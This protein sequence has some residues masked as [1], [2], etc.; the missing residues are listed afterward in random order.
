MKE[1]TTIK[2]PIIF[3]NFK[4]YY[5]ATGERA[6]RL[7]QLCEE[8]AKR[9]GFDIRL[10]VQAADIYH[11]SE[12][13]SLPIYAEHID[14][15]TPGRSTGFILPED[16]HEEGAVGTILNHSEHRLK[17]TVLEQSVNRAREVGLKMVIC[18]ATPEE[19]ESFTTLKP[20]FIAVEPPELI[21]GLVSVSS[22]KPEIISDAVKRIP[23]P[24]L[25][26]AGIHTGADINTALKLG[27]VG[28]LIASSV[29]KSIDPEKA[30]K[31]LLEEVTQP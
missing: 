20:D 8:F 25:V 22:A 7:A 1:K 27:A 11:I 26:G 18:A 19:G 12:K 28:V 15:I 9:R 29:A 3:I 4:T 13:T 17:R 2:R 21:G 14:P 16:V 6:L 31:T 5:S 10:V 23:L 30:L 24:L